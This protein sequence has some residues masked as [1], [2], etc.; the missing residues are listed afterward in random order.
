MTV[1]VL[2]HG[3]FQGFMVPRVLD[4]PLVRAAV[5]VQVNEARKWM[6]ERLL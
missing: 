6:M 1:L 5:D 3:P 4:G 2:T